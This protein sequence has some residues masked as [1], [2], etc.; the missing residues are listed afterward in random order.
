[1]IRIPGFPGKQKTV[2]TKT[3]SRYDSLQHYKQKKSAQTISEAHC[4]NWI[5]YFYC[6]SSILR[7]TRVI[8]AVFVNN[9]ISASIT[10]QISR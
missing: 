1:M 3:A 4:R 5:K 7:K 9:L 8:E 6:H 10:W 2:V